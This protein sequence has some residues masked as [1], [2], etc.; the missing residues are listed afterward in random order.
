MLPK[1]RLKSFSGDKL[2]WQTFWEGFS[3]AI[4]DTPE[5]SD[6]ETMN[7]L[8]GQLRGEAARAIAGLPLTNG[9][10]RKAVELLRERYGTTEKRKR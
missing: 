2:E 9:N 3:S 8:S 4:D 1:L 7:Y 10:Y 5:L 6:I